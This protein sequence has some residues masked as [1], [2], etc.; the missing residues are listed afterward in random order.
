MLAVIHEIKPLVTRQIW[1]GY[2]SGSA[3]GSFTWKDY[4]LAFLVSSLEG[5]SCIGKAYVQTLSLLQSP[6]D[7]QVK[8][9]RCFIARSAKWKEK[10]PHFCRGCCES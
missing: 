10:G 6:D 8:I 2:E 3:L 7:L 1:L 5:L 4:S 9:T